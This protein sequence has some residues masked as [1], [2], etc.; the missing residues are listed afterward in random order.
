[1]KFAEVSLFTNHHKRDVTFVTSAAQ[2]KTVATYEHNDAEI[3]RFRDDRI[4]AN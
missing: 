4:C 3:I 1:M 2:T